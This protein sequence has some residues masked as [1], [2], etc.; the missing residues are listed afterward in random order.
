MDKVFVDTACPREEILP[1]ASLGQDDIVTGRII[2]SVS[3]F[4]ILNYEL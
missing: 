2:H 4:I 1:R 3:V